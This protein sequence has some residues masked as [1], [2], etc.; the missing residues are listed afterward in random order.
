MYFI[1]FPFLLNHGTVRSAVVTAE[2]SFV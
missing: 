1:F 2:F